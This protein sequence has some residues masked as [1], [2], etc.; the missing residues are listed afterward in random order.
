V[1]L[2]RGEVADVRQQL[3]A[4]DAELRAATLPGDALALVDAVRALDYGDAAAPASRFFDAV[5]LEATRTPVATV[6]NALDEVL[7]ERNSVVAALARADAAALAPL[8]EAEIRLRDALG[9]P[10][11]AASGATDH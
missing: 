10:V 8:R 1:L 5:R 2:L 3:A 6:Q 9:Y 7:Q 4:A 11:A